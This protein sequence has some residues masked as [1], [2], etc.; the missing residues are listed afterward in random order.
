M[1]SILIPCLIYWDRSIASGHHLSNIVIVVFTLPINRGG[2]PRGGINYHSVDNPRGFKRAPLKLMK[3]QGRQVTSRYVGDA[4]NPIHTLINF[5]FFRSSRLW[6]RT[7]REENHAPA[8][9]H[10]KRPPSYSSI[11]YCPF[12]SHLNSTA[13]TNLVSR[14]G[15]DSGHDLGHTL[16]KS[17]NA[18]KERVDGRG[19]RPHCQAI[20]TA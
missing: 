18:S 20:H 17:L 16:S 13:T 19:D 10:P 14:R 2:V 3:H 15:K 7:I 12:Y 4:V 8:C 11:H 6:Y 5:C 1:E 9:H